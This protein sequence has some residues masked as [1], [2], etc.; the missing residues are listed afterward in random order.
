VK[1]YAD[2]G[3]PIGWTK[4]NATLDPHAKAC[5][6]N[7]VIRLPA[8]D[9]DCKSDEKPGEFGWWPVAKLIGSLILGGLLI[10]LG[11]PFWYD[12]VTG[13]TNI[14]SIAKDIAGGDPAKKAAPPAP[15]PQGAQTEASPAPTQ[16]PAAKTPDRLQPATPVGAFNIAQAALAAASNQG[17]GS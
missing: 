11:G 1:Q 15:A 8:A 5:S 17:G 2:L 12:V 7:G 13:L 14:R 3:L 9:E 4:Q 6:K 10:G 16:P